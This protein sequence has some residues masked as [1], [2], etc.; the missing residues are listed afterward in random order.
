MSSTAA[1]NTVVGQGSYTLAGVAWFKVR[2]NAKTHG[3]MNGHMDDQGY[4]A[5]A[6]NN[7]LFPSIGVTPGGKK[8]VITFTLSGPDYFPSSAYAVLGRRR[9]T[10]PRPVSG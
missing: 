7:V 8:A 1:L 2:P 6:G 10:S 9:S 4:Y 3:T 5:P